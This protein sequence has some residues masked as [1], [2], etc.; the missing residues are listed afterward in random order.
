MTNSAGDG[1]TPPSLPGTS[2]P[3]DR[4]RTTLLDTSDNVLAK[5]VA[6]A[7]PWLF[8]ALRRALIPTGCMLILVVLFLA[9]P[10][11]SEVLLGLTEPVSQ[12]ISGND[13]ISS[14]NT[15][16]LA[17][18]LLWSVLLSLGIW[19]SARLLCTVEAWLGM[20]LVWEIREL[21]PHWPLESEHDDPR[22]HINEIRVKIAIRLMPRAY[23][24]GTLALSMG[25][26][27]LATLFSVP[28]F[29]AL[30][31]VAGL[32][33]S[34]LI[35]AYSLLKLHPKRQHGRVRGWSVLAIGCVLYVV[36][37]IA[38]AR[39]FRPEAHQSVTA[40]ITLDLLCALLPALVLTCLAL[41]R[42]VMRRI[43][44]TW[45]RRSDKVFTYDVFESHHALRFEDVFWQVLMFVVIGA[46]LLLLLA[47][48]PAKDVRS[49]G[50]IGTI[51]LF[52]AAAV[53]A[54]S[55]CQ[56]FLRRIS[57]AVP[58]FTSAVAIIAML[59][60][61]F[62]S[63]ER[64]GKESI[65][66]EVRGREPGE[67]VVTAAYDRPGNPPYLLVNAYG[68]GLRAAIFT[69]QVLALADDAS[70]GEF[71]K[72]LYAL[73]GVSGGSLGI[74]VYLIARQTLVPAHIWRDCA[75]QPATSPLPTPL[76]DVVTK[77]LVQD[78]LSPVIAK[79]LSVDVFL[80]TPLTPY[81]YA[82]RG[83]AML[84]SW[85]DALVEALEPHD[86]SSN[87]QDWDFPLG[88]P[89]DQLNGA[90]TPAPRVYFNTTDADTGFGKWFSNGAGG[91]ALSN[92]DRRSPVPRMTVGQ[93]VLHSARFPYA[94]PAG[95]YDDA[96]QARRL[97]DGGYADNSG[98]R[99]L[100]AQVL[101]TDAQTM[102]DRDDLVLLDI[103]GNP[104]AADNSETAST[105][106][107]R[108][109]ATESSIPTALLALLQARAARADDAVRELAHAL[110]ACRQNDSNH[111]C[112]TPLQIGPEPDEQASRNSEPDCD[113]IENTRTI[114]LGWYTG[115]G[116]AQLVAQ[117]A[118]AKVQDVC[119]RAHVAC[120]S[121]R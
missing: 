116:A 103:N 23:A 3:V 29:K 91:E 43:Y 10:E 95:A 77:A 78:H 63:H 93:A 39:H 118:K 60:L 97:V 101:A 30:L 4:R 83:Q 67:P 71:G 20:P 115:P 46:T 49:I 106:A 2:S 42:P 89:I 17:W 69:A 107:K 104:P 35:F 114:P 11:T 5:C 21:G 25:A 75:S 79:A 18:Y 38:L 62:F 26:L 54:I 80:R 31:I 51:M 14:L 19:Y 15:A 66:K 112:L 13:S 88:L 76:T 111:K 56:L 9:V 70:C 86:I 109:A 37:G 12:H 16:P 61:Q 65:G 73:S 105:C 58:G 84:N 64:L 119:D 59:V 33:A 117:S 45:F 120:R 53:V 98:A 44:K 34:P 50:S 24:V 68:G 72:H 87:V 113:Q 108:A 110:P 6:P 1:E 57:R 102:P 74:A 55:G 121:L 36:S 92:F 41:R 94:T 47:N 32:I 85:N 100:L 99:T 28:R 48:L 7:M 90:I 82:R 8:L 96:G 40:V 27:V 22:K 81:A 52:L